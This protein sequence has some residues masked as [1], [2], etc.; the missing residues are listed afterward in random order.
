MALQLGGRIYH[1]VGQFCQGLL[2][3]I[4][5]SPEDRSYEENITQCKQES[6]KLF[7]KY[8][9]RF[10]DLL[11]HCLHHDVEKWR[12]CQILYD[13]LDY[14]NKTLLEAMCEGKFLKKDENKGWKIYEDLAEKPYNGNLP[15]KSIG[16]Q[17][18]SLQKRSPLDREFHSNW[19]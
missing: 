19:G 8:F 15:M 13:G 16:L 6:N 3:K 11:V 4:L 9:E 18:L 5:P 17:T 2:K 7:W 10:E 1:N 14:Q 12:L